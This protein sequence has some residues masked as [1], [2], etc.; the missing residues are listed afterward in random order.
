M[1]GLAFL[2]AV[3]YA[4]AK[5]GSRKRVPPYVS[6]LIC[7]T[8]L[9]WMNISSVFLMAGYRG[10]IFH[11]LVSMTLMIIIL[12]SV[13]YVIA[14]R[15]KLDNANISEEESNKGRKMIFGWLA[16]SIILLLV[17]AEITKR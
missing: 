1:K 17:A 2:M 12:P 11:P 6:T 3:F 14:N 7:F 8:L 13:L 15:N 4:G 5:S 9:I 10:F 16:V